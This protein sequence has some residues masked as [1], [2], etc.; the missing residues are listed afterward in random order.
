MIQYMIESKTRDTV[1]VNVKLIHKLLNFTCGK[2]Y[3]NLQNAKDYIFILTGLGLSVIDIF[4]MCVY[5]IMKNEN[6]ETNKKLKVIKIAADLQHK[7]VNMDR[8]ILVLDHFIIQL[9]QVFY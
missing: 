2:G 3:I 6:I 7:S 8:P 4:K 1:P 9:N 5:E